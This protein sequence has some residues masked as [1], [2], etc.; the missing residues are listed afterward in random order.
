VQVFYLLRGLQERGHENVLLC[1]R[2]TA[3]AGRARAVGVRVEEVPFAGDFDLRLASHTRRLVRALR[4]DVVHLHSRRGA[5]TLGG[6]GARWGRAPA[7]VL[8]RRVDD[9]VKPN[10]FN[11]LRYGPLCDRIVTI[12]EGIREVLLAAGLPPDKIVC[13]RSALDPTPYDLP[14][15]RVGLRNEFGF[16]PD[17]RVIGLIGQFIERK[18]HRFLLEALP[19]V[20]AAQPQIG[21][22]FCGRG[23]LEAELRAEV[24]QRGLAEV[25]R[26]A[27]FREDIPQILAGLDVVVHPAL[28]EGLGIVLLQA[29]AARRPLVASAVGGIPEAVRDGENGLLVPPADP[30]ALA[31]AVCRLLSDPERAARMGQRGREIVE[32]EFSVEQMVAGNWRVYEE[33]LGRPEF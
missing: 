13:V 9:P 29:M 20:R 7:I 33:L 12:S 32:Q 17:A 6:L 4:P 22:L 8:S 28:R 27:G 23:P 19:A 11:R 5:D 1:P 24:R 31:E 21:V 26:F 30:V 25:V 2:G 3:L 15:R 10:W 18:G 14:D 16:P